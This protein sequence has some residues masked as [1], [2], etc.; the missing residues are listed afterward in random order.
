MKDATHK[1]LWIVGNKMFTERT[2][3]IFT[4][5]PW[6][7]F[8]IFRQK[9]RFHGNSIFQHDFYSTK[10]IPLVDN[11]IFDYITL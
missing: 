4:S 8:I 7:D 6:V 9:N 11:G 1:K 2:Q 10:K 3:K 5:Y